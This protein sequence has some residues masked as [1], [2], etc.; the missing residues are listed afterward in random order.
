V[1]EVGLGGKLDATN[2]V[3]DNVVCSVITS[4]DMDHTDVLGDTLEEIA[5]EKAGV[6]KPGIP[7]VL[8]PTC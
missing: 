6:I 1:L 3:D 2:V 5:E 7:V 8:G 4:L